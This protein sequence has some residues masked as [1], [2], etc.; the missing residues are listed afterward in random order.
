[1]AISPIKRQSQ[2]QD[3]NPHLPDL[4]Y[5]ALDILPAL[6][7]PTIATSFIGRS[8]LSCILPLN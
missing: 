4:F 6:N 7:Y 3:L 1:M 2:G 5:G 8:R